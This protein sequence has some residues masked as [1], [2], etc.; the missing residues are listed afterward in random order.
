ME[1]L[2]KL[3]PISELLGGKNFFIPSYQRGY[4][5]S[6]I[7]I[8][9][10]LNDIYVFAVKPLKSE[11]E[12]YCLQPIVVK[13]CSPSII[14]KNDLNSELDN[15][16]WYEVIDGQQRLTTIRILLSY[17]VN[18]LYPGH[19]LFNKHKKHPFNIEYET[20]KGCTAFIDQNEEN[21]DF[22]DFH[23]ISEARKVISKWFSETED[24]QLAKEKIRN[25]LINK[26]GNIIE[27]VVQ[28]IWYEITDNNTNPIDVFIRIN[29]GKISLTNAELIKA[30]FL[31]E[32]N[33]GEGDIAKLK[34]LE[35]AQD[36]DRIEN[37][38]QDE[39]FWWF[40]NK[41]ENKA[42]S[43][44]E[45]IFDMMCVKALTKDAELKKIIGEDQYQTF[46]YFNN[47]IGNSPNQSTI[48][49]LWEDVISIFQTFK[50]WFNNPEWYHYIGF[51]IYC[52]KSVQDIFNMLDDSKVKQ[53]SDATDVLITQIKNEFK[54]V[55]WLNTSDDKEL[56]INL[57]YNSDKMLLRKFFLLFNLEYI[58]KQS[59]QEN[60][61]YK[62]LFK[63]FK[64]KKIK[65]EPLFWDI[66]H[67]S[68]STDNSLDKFED[69]KIW[70][71]NALLDIT[72]LP[73]E[74]I[75]EIGL[76]I[77]SNNSDKFG[78]LYMRVIEYTSENNINDTLK[79]CIGNLTLLDAGTNRG[80]GNALFASKRRI[81]IKKDNEGH[82]I[83]L[84]T[85]NVFL[86]Y[87]DGNTQS[88]W[89]EADIIG[90]RNVLE[91]TMSK[92]IKDKPVNNE[93]K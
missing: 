27:G 63:Y 34:Q 26:K 85:K 9:D 91:V 7:Q 10:L 57:S 17:L 66:E 67:I 59:K 86:K 65:R 37:E 77:K 32:R 70:F 28:V 4:R 64:I 5:W 35:I 16:V 90:Y 53:K 87:F 25:I 12:F 39:N 36:W 8:E 84:C 49:E 21:D 58:I 74:L 73:N 42:S 2:I 72:D 88:K 41:D 62:F 79:N 61:I 93:K 75:E 31:Q 47:K 33:F 68:S 60:L 76:F 54:D 56:H 43:H 50:E 6:K 40:L 3:Y 22:I 69:Q 48:K 55:N 80:Y 78:N 89:I 82:F 51:L 20:R 15:N 18:D 14:Q 92:F 71:E 29:L 83:P 30:L 1:N 11:K 81:I 52:G 44:I 13:V 23:F 19:T 45:F 24:P 46:R 38:L